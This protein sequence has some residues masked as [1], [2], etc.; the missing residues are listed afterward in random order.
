ME[1]YGFLLPP[2][3]DRCARFADV[4]VCDFCAIVAILSADFKSKNK[5]KKGVDI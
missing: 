1:E 5:I 4:S 2:L 3:R